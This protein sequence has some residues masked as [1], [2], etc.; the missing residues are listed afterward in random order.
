LHDWNKKTLLHRD[1]RVFEA[2][3]YRL[4]EPTLSVE[5]QCGQLPILC[6][7]PRMIQQRLLNAPREAGRP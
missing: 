3:P 4:L 2:P 5:Q 7:K 6:G 1:R